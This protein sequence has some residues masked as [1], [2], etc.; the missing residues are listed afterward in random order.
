MT[1]LTPRL[2][3]LPP[4]QKALWPDL[5]QTPAHFTLYGGT[6]IALQLGHRQSVDFDFFALS[7]IDTDQLLLSVP[8]LASA[9]ILHRERNSITCLI[10]RGGPV[11]LSYFGLP[12]LKRLEEPLKTRDNGIPCATL[13]DL[14]GTKAQV[15]Q[16]RAETKD[17]ID[18]DALL[19]SGISLDAHL[20]AARHI[21]GR[22]FEPFPTLKALSHYD[23][24]DLPEAVQQRLSTAVAAVDLASLSSPTSP[25][26][27]S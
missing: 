11:K 2:D 22:L 24:L 12:H 18:I 27:Q 26:T 16:A 8:Y 15:I 23:G 3:I 7:D 10:D 21:Y 6:A 13:L 19:A 20:R 4:P 25:W 9:R 5:S 17:Y 1:L 14:A